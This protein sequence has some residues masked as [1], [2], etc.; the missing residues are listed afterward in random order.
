[1]FIF[2]G[3]SDENVVGI[4]KTEMQPPKDL[5][6]IQVNTNRL[7]GVMMAVFGRN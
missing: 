3:A 6:G 2:E 1:M 4:N 7:K 5:K